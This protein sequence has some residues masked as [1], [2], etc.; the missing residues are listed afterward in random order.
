[1]PLLWEIFSDYLYLIR[2]LYDVEIQSF[3]LMSNHYHLLIRTPEAN[4]PKAMNYFQREL[5]RQVNRHSNRINQVW[6]ER[7]A[8]SMILNRPHMYNVYKYVYR[9]PVDAG[10]AA[11]VEQYRYS[12][13]HGLLG[14]SPLTIPLL[15]DQI[16]FADLTAV[17]HWLNLPFPRQH[18]REAIRKALR[19]RQFEFGMD[20]D[21]KAPTPDAIS[22]TF[23]E[24]VAGTF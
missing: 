9:N 11:T 14:Q 21:R 20:R 17:L 16:L 15:E 22:T 5:A 2:S 3:V 18:T 6:G 23:P 19:H 7:Y 10:L 8:W 4:L 13:L 24:K 12:T 1:M